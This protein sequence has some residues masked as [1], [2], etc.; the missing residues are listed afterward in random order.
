MTILLPAMAKKVNYLMNIYG[1]RKIL[2]RKHGLSEYQ[3]DNDVERVSFRVCH[4]TVF[5]RGEGG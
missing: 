5:R 4:V 3:R 1:R 2:F